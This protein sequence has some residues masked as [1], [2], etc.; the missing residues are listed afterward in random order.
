M[1]THPYSDIGIRRLRCA[2]TGCKNRAEFQWQIC[3]D[4]NQYRP[5]CRECDI[6]LNRIVLRFMGWKNWKEKITAYIRKKA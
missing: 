2:R 4:G 5:L 6:A 1:R 3:A